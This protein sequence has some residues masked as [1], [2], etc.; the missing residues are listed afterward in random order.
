MEWNTVQEWLSGNSVYD[1]ADISNWVIWGKPAI[2]LEKEKTSQILISSVS[3][4]KFPM[5]YR[6]KE[7]PKPSNWK[8]LLENIREYFYSS[9]CEKPSSL[10]WRQ[11]QEIHK[12]KKVTYLTIL[13]LKI[14][15]WILVKG[16]LWKFKLHMLFD[17]VILI[18]QNLLSDTR[19]HLWKD[20]WVGIRIFIS[21]YL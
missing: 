2:H 5:N 13:I 11:R 17:I 14:A 15:A 1:K 9:G 10:A 16:N 8:L 19:T 4:N 3:Q 20:L 7:S 6:Y 21:H 12:K 18:L